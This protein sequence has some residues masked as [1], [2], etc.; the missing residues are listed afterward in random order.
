[1]TIK[2]W[3]K[4]NQ[5][6]I[7]NNV[8]MAGYI[9]LFFGLPEQT[10][11]QVLNELFF[12]KYKL[13]KLED[14]IETVEDMNKMVSMSMARKGEYY[15]AINK[16]ILVDFDPLQ[17]YFMETNTMEV[18]DGE[19]TNTGSTSDTTNNTNTDTTDVKLNTFDNQTLTTTNQETNTGSDTSTS[20][21]STSSSNE[22]L[23][24]KDITSTRKGYEFID[25]E[26]VI[27]AVYKSKETNL[28]D[29]IVYDLKELIC[30]NIY[31]F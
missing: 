12:E 19:S 1:M 26:K 30:I 27:K 6:Q 13:L 4:N 10:V 7:F 29:I 23:D 15:K 14:D 9:D 21:G 18:R 2:E 28:F 8:N 5:M 11:L 17:T 22:Y 16:A 3:M 31:E 24:N 20:T 25:F